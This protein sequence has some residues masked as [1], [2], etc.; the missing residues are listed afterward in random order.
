MSVIGWRLRHGGK[1]CFVKIT[2]RIKM[3]Y[4][5]NLNFKSMADWSFEAFN[6]MNQS[7]AK[8]EDVNPPPSINDGDA[9]GL[10]D[11]HYRVIKVTSNLK[12]DSGSPFLEIR[13]LVARENPE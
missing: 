11:V 5:F 2:T 10:F 12:K 7:I 8:W 13:G 1:N 6:N 9:F 3:S 4:L